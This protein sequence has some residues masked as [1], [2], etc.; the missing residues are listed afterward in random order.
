MTWGFGFALAKAGLDHFPPLLLMGLRFTTAALILIWFVPVPRGHWGMLG[1]IALVSATLQYGLTFSGLALIDATP[2]IFLVQ[3]EVVFGTVIAVIM[4]REWPTRR[5]VTGIGVSLAGIVTIVGAPSLEGQMTGVSLVLAGGLCW[6]FGQVLVRRL[7]TALT[8]FQLTAWIGVI[9]APQMLLASVIIEGNP[10]PALATASI[11]DWA[12]VAYLGVVMT[13]IGYSAWY[14]L[15]A[16]YP[17]PMVL[18]LLLLLPVSTILGAIGFLGERPDAHVL[19]GGL[20]VIGGVGAV[21]VEP[22]EIRK[23]WKPRDG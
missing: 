10:L 1:V 6:A 2:A 18:P 14:F 23:L 4:L 3:S 12:T 11:G 5:Q 7:G 16:R 17:V 19:I 22:S 21:I 13:V 20:I 15:L 9:A 8:G